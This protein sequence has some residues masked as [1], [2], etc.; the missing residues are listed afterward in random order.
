MPVSR[1]SLFLRASAAIVNQLHG[2]SVCFASFNMVTPKS[3]GDENIAAADGT[4]IDLYE[5][6]LLSSYHI[7][8]G[9]YG[10]IAYHVVSS[11]CIALYSH[12]LN[13]GMWEGNFLLDALMGNTS[14]IQPKV[15]HS[16][17]RWNQNRS[18]IYHPARGSPSVLT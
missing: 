1:F 11:L 6:N 12:F 17:I 10:G 8:Y 4:K 2:L 18:S 5:N 16:D 14:E 7:R 3:W 15:I 13:C 9:S